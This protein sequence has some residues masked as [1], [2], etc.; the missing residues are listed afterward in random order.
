MALGDSTAKQ[1]RAVWAALS[2]GHKL[3]L[4]LLCFVSVAA[5]VGVAFWAGEPDYQMAYTD[6]SS[7][8]CASLVAALKDAGIAARVAED[9]TAVMVP[10]ARMYEARMAAAEKG[11]SA[12]TGGGFEA[13]RDPK[14]GMTP[15][16]ERVNYISA[17]QSELATTI[18]SLEAVV[19]ARVHVVLPERTVFRKDQR[20]AS[21]SVLAVTRA[22]Q[23]LRREEVLGIA[24]LVASAVEGLSPEDVTITDGRGHVL[25]GAE[26]DGPE[27]VAD[28]QFAYRQRV[29][30]YLSEKA[31]SMLAKVIGY[32]RCEVRVSAELDFQD[33][34]E[35][36]RTYD[37]DKKVVV[38]EKIESTKTTGGGTEVGGPVGAAGNVPGEEQAASSRPAAAQLSTTEN[39]QTEYE[40]SESVLETVNRGASIKRLTVAAFVDL[41]IPPAESGAEGA[42]PPTLL[43][44]ERAIKDAVGLDET[45]G[46]SLKIVEAS[47]HPVTAELDEV[48]A[49]A[50]EWLVT[51]GQYFAIGALGLVLLLVS[52]RVLRN[53]EAAAPRRVVVPEVMGAEGELLAA[54]PNQDEMIH[55]EISKF[56]QEN[57]EAAGRMLEGWVEGEE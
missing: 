6:L 1:Y 2:A 5:V 21:A 23:A 24:N 50:P 17:L 39:I 27:M 55:R 45:R 33:S 15:F 37:P 52:R 53:I 16:A 48:S 10:S 4:V 42:T 7:K 38:T 8:E 34:R 11:I 46:D 57:P 47:F 22:G 49:G 35:T 30:A 31:E 13:F 19:Y 26:G 29:E 14:I 18:T 54:R 28:D 20:R 9:G 25:A 40:V 41:S 56:V 3:I 12:G 32:G 43:D 44:I 51:A 36:K